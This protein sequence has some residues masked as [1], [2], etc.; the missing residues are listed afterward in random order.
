[1]IMHIYVYFTY[2]TSSQHAILCATWS[3]NY[4]AVSFSLDG[5]LVRGL[6]IT[7]ITNY[8]C[9]YSTGLMTQLKSFFH[10]VKLVGIYAVYL[11]SR[12]SLKS[13]LF[14]NPFPSYFSTSSS[15]FSHSFFGYLKS[16]TILITLRPRHCK[17]LRKFSQFSSAL[18]SSVPKIKVHAPFSIHFE[19]LLD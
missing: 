15:S 12:R 4:P 11:K 2:R 6:E 9:M 18:I 1:M 14:I 5:L 7:S 10:A 8:M 3:S 16:I 13:F 17:E 19:L